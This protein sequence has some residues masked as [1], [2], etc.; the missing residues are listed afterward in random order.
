[1]PM[2]R[3]PIVD[4]NGTGTTGTILNNSWKQELY[5]Q[6]D[7]VAGAEVLSV[8]SGGN[9]VLGPYGVHVLLLNPGGPITITWSGGAGLDG[10]RVILLQRTN[11]VTTCRGHKYR[12]H[13]QHRDECADADRAERRGDLYA[14]GGAGLVPH[15][16]SS[17]VVDRGAVCG[18][19]F[20]RGCRDLDR[21]GRGCR[22]LGVSAGGPHAVGD[23]QSRHDHRRGQSQLA[24][25]S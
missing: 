9:V 23:V 16:A 12:E 11:T 19:Q 10:E 8:A 22:D 5:T 18:R 15:G 14:R 24:A 1:M 2:T 21:R 4:D 17:R 6:I 7:A 3:T 13:F 20:L 25:K